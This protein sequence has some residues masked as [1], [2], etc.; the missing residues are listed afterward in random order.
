MPY[1]NQEQRKNLDDYVNELIFN[2]QQE[3]QFEKRLGVT[4]Y[5]ITRIVLGLLKPK[6][7]SDMCGVIGTF[8]S[9]KLECYRRLVGPYEDSAITT[10]G[11]LEEY[12]K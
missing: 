7:Y 5:I 12:K 6:N 8:E 9:A 2:A 1:I 11:D 4:N 10:N 3:T